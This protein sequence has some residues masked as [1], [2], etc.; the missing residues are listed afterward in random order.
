MQK[1]LIIGFDAVGRSTEDRRGSAVGRENET[2][3]RPLE[4]LRDLLP[5]R[6]NGRNGID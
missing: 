2:V 6:G 4:G 1:H 5:D 3:F